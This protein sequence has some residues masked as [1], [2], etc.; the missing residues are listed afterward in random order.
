MEESANTVHMPSQKVIAKNYLEIAYTLW[1]QL[2]PWFCTGAKKGENDA[3]SFF[4]FIYLYRIEDLV[5]IFA[6]RKHRVW[7]FH[8]IYYFE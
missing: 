8:Y 2:M 6:V 1:T 5:T 3:K 7:D 4:L